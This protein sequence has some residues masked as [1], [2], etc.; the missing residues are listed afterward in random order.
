[1]LRTPFHWPQNVPNES[2]ERNIIEQQESQ[3]SIEF[4]Q[5]KERE[6]YIGSQR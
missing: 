1:M 5:A 6:K 2:E 4:P 3:G